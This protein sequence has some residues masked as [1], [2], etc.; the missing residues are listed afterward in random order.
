M[1]KSLFCLVV[2]L[3][4]K[5]YAQNH[6]T[7]DWI[8]KNSIEIEDAD[9]DSKLIGFSNNVPEKFKNAKI[10]GFGELSHDGKEYFN[11]K[12]KFFKH[13]VENYGVRSFIM[14]AGYQAESSINEWITGTNDDISAIGRPFQI[15][16]WYSEEVFNLL[17]WMRI[18]NLN[19][20]EEDQIKFYG[21]DVQSGKN[22][23]CEVR[24]FI[25]NYGIPVQPD[26]LITLDKCS[27]KP[28]DYSSGASGWAD[29]Q[30]PNLV[31]LQN[32]INSYQR[33]N[34]LTNLREFE[35]VTRSIDVLIRYTQYVQ[36]PLSEV[37]DKKMFENAKW[38]I[39]QESKNGKAFI[40]AHNEHINNRG[41]WSSNSGIENLGKHLKDYYG[42]GY[43][44][45][46][47][48]FGI[49]KLK[50][51]KNSKGKKGEW[52]IHTIEKPFKNTYSHTLFQ[53]D[54]AIIFIDMG[55]AS[56]GDKTIFFSTSNNTLSIGGGGFQPKPLHRIKMSKIYTEQ[57]DGLIFI[58]EISPANNSVKIN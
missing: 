8:N 53:A 50:G 45:V 18:Y 3:T 24:S 41:M 43:Y 9:P 39:E 48:D 40:W 57:Y 34:Q 2:I 10:F 54:K 27:E 14:E 44:S 30:A 28:I 52:L 56:I 47:F 22:L 13:L 58:K 19:R 11:I 16:F 33:E 15:G 4:F 12:A 25:E 51:Y 36:D 6:E 5:S 38:V 29:V 1:K 17:K 42:N 49:G 55:Q 20:P 23:N 46:G 26:L 7:I 31:E 35:L 32:Q 37:R 21:M